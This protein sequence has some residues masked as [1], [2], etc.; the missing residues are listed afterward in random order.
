MDPDSGRLQ[1]GAEPGKLRLQPSGIRLPCSRQGPVMLAIDDFNTA[2][3]TVIPL[4]C[5]TITSLK[6]AHSLRTSMKSPESKPAS[7]PDGRLRPSLQ[8]S[9]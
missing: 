3:I 7:L 5:A 6:V 4:A 2:G 8:R 1:H 9:P